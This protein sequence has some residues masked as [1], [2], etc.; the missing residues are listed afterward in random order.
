MQKAEAKTQTV[1]QFE[2]TNFSL[3]LS[4]SLSFFLFFFLS[5]FSSTSTNIL[6]LTVKQE[7]RQI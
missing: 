6:R 7:I 5:E 1:M 3:Y 2:I 4:L